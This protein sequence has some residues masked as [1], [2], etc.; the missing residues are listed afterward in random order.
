MSDASMDQL[1]E[2]EKDRLSK[3]NPMLYASRIKEIYSVYIEFIEL[4]NDLTELGF[5]VEEK[6]GSKIKI[7]KEI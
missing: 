3:I 4:R 6:P 2:Q 7:W 5:K 1:R